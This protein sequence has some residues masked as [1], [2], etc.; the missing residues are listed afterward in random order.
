LTLL[1]VSSTNVEETNAAIR[2]GADIIDVKNPEE[3]SLGANFPWVIAEIRKATPANVPLSAS[4]GDFPNLPGSAALA[5]LGALKA[6]ADIIK[7]G[8]KGPRD[9]ESAAYLL[10]QVVKAVKGE[11]GSARVVA[12]AYG[13][14]R[15]ARTI[16]FSILPK[17]AKEA[18][19]DVVMI[20]TAVKDGKPITDFLGM[21]ELRAFVD[22]AHSNGL[23]AALAGSLKYW[24][25]KTLRGL[26]PDVIGVRGAVCEGGDRRSGRISEELV[27][28]LKG[29]LEE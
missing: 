11:S 28:R 9:A 8:L 4:I 20:D 23:W 12:C 27:R 29:L 1:L 13:D 14:F 18:G 10:Q 7:V 16:D 22:E 24:E 21:S 17:I 25:I 15:R 2:G 19:A 6:G 26:G 5:A 3:G